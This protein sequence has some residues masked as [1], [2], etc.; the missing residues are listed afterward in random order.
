MNTDDAANWALQLMTEHFDEAKWDEGSKQ[1]WGQP[2][3]TG[4]THSYQNAATT[5]RVLQTW[6]AVEDHEVVKALQCSSDAIL[7]RQRMWTWCK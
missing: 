6:D 2:H 3:N 5:P 7:Q 4:A 1:P